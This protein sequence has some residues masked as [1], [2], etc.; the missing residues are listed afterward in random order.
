MDMTPADLD[1]VAE[2]ELDEEDE[3]DEDERAGHTRRWVRYVMPVM[4]EVDCD[5]DVF[6]I[7]CCIIGR[8]SWLAIPAGTFSSA[9]FAKVRLIANFTSS[10][11]SSRSMI[12]HLS[13]GLL[14]TERN[15]CDS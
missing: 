10:S 13:T 14:P 1:E 9:A 7:A 8:A 6:L 5:T 15:N 4:V 12:T 3:E 11:F 2:D